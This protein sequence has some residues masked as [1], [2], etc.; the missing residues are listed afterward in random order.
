MNGELMTQS[1]AE[2]A[3]FALEDLKLD[4]LEGF[5]AARGVLMG[6]RCKD[7]STVVYPRAHVCH[8][9]RGVRLVPEDL[10]NEGVLQAFTR[11]QVS[12][13]R[14]VPYTIGY[15]DLPGDVR[16]LAPLKDSDELGCD[17]PVTLVGDSSGWAFEV[18]G[19]NSDV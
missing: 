6:S 10:P 15:V 19:E 4:A 11:V 7:C 18:T 5:D 9:C 3:L 13:D 2:Q 8:H 14:P 17:V 16:L 12:S 1:H